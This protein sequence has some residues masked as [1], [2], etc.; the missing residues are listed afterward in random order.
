LIIG[1]AALRLR[2]RAVV[3][4]AALCTVAVAA[5]VVGA[6]AF[7]PHSPGWV[8]GAL[9]GC[10]FAAWAGGTVHAF[11]LRRRVFR[12]DPAVV[13][14]RVAREAAARRLEL[15][16]HAR[17]IVTANP[18]LAHELLIGRPDQ[19]RAYDDGGLIAVNQVPVQCLM[20]LPGIDQAA[21]RRIVELRD[22]RGPFVSDEDLL[23]ATGLPPHLLEQF[24]EYTVYLHW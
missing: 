24:A 4:S 8:N 22:H 10:V 15:R 5:V 16:T 23:A 19:P 21:A 7:G 3:I 6:N 9:A 14:N 18:A 2:S 11:A 1:H 20:S 17:E 13:G 12:P